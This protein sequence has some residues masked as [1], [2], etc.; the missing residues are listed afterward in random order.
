MSTDFKEG[1]TKNCRK[2][3][4]FC[5]FRQF[6]SCFLGFWHCRI[7]RTLSEN[8]QFTCTRCD[9]GQIS[10]SRVAFLNVLKARTSKLSI[11]ANMFI[12]E[13]QLW[14][15]LEIV[16]LQRNTKG[17]RITYLST[18]R[19]S[20]IKAKPLSTDMSLFSLLGILSNNQHSSTK[21]I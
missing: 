13:K 11:H 6:G 18:M 12:D 14:Y 1:T 20:S 4:C 5:S 3:V 19:W 8:I 15:P 21:P 2:D 17:I 9:I 10:L 16:S 7:I